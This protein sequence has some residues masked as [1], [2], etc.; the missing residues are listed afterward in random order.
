MY[1]VFLGIMCV[2][3]VLAH[4]WSYIDLITFCNISVNI[5]VSVFM[6]SSCSD[7]S[8][9]FLSMFLSTTDLLTYFSCAKTIGYAERK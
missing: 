2:M 4:P 1:S 7:H 3:F 9:L 8:H 5:Y 6:C